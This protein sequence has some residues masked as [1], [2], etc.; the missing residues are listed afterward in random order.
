[1]S[2]QDTEPELNSHPTNDDHEE[3]SIRRTNKKRK[4]LSCFPCRDRKMKCDRVY[5]ICGRCQKTERREQCTYDPRLLDGPR[6]SATANAGSADASLALSEQVAPETYHEDGLADTLRWKVRVQERRIEM[7]ERKL[8]A[9]ESIKPQSQYQDHLA[10]GE[11]KIEEET[12]LRG[13]GFKTLFHGS[14]SVRSMIAHVRLHTCLL[15]QSI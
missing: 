12:M 3:S 10:G 15:F 4:V 6:P 2:A 13:K 5:P 14:T 1:M 7:L 9:K 8:A 11:P